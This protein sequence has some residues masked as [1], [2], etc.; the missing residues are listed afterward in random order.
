MLDNHAD[1]EEGDLHPIGDS[2]LEDLED[3]SLTRTSCPITL[4]LKDSKPPSLLEDLEKL[5]C[6]TG[7]SSTPSNSTSCSYVTL[8]CGNTPSFPVPSIWPS[9]ACSVERRHVEVNFEG[10]MREYESHYNFHT[11][12]LSNSP[13]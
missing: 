12:W 8:K 6:V 1:K 9:S 2:T 10:N 5:S 13:H 11:N 4:P 3:K 7:T